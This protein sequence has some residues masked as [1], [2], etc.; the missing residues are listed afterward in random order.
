MQPSDPRLRWFEAAASHVDAGVVIH[1]PDTAI[2]YANQRAIEM[3]GMTREELS[4]MLAVDP[5][6][7]LL[8]EDGRDL[9]LERYPVVR[10]LERGEDISDQIVGT[11]HPDSTEAVWARVSVVLYPHASALES[12]VVTFVDITALRRAEEERR[13]AQ[14]QAEEAARLESLALLAGGVAHDFNN[15]LTS[16]LGA[17]EIAKPQAEGDLLPLLDV[18]GVSALRAGEL[19]RQL[20]AYAGRGHVV[21]ELVDPAALVRELTKIARANYAPGVSLRCELSP[22]PPLL[23]DATQLRQVVLNLL[24]NAGQAIGEGP[25]QVCVRCHERQIPTDP[26]VHVLI[27]VEDDGPGMDEATQA[28]IFEPFFT[29]KPTGTGLGLS[30]VQGFVQAQGGRVQV[31]S[32]PGE[33][34]IFRLDLPAQVGALLPDSASQP[35][36]SLSSAVILDDDPLIRRLV[37]KL[38]ADGG[39]RVSALER[40]HELLPCLRRE[41]PD[42]VV[43]DLQLPDA[44]GATLLR[45]LRAEWPSLPV[46]MC[47]GYAKPSEVQDL[48]SDEPTRF[49]SKPFTRAQ[50]WSA[51]E[52]LVATQAPIS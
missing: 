17:A 19:T 52:G 33:G 21:R 31:E 40:G 29:T 44:S 30:A 18:I 35:K 50:F 39:A 37:G 36:S 32:S 47:S 41:L 13:K 34:T 23:I 16:I 25:G 46:L 45:E 42:V 20:L 24:V 9:P 51:L 48:A 5:K 8:D 6:L 49:L 27:E 14:A 43:L 15:L 11:L 12:L 10:A 3:L 28:R 38:L 22:S 2:L 4:G 7:R 1:A 26:R